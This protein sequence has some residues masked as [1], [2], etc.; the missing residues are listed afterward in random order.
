[1]CLKPRISVYKQFLFYDHWSLL[2][3]HPRPAHNYFIFERLENEKK[4]TKH[5]K[6]SKE[7][8]YSLD[9]PYLTPTLT[10]QKT[11][12]AYKKYIYIFFFQIICPQSHTLNT[13]NS[14]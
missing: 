12:T 7:K 4:S 11:V 6:I 14:K 3:I 9:C 8:N 2:S 13:Y 10:Q 5:L 1:M